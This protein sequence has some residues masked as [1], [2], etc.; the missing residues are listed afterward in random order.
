MKLKRSIRLQSRDVKV[1]N[2]PM[3]DIIFLLLTFFMISSSFSI[4]PGIKI[5]L[6]KTVT[7]ESQLKEEM[8]LTLNV[9]G[10]MFLNNE[11]VSLES[12]GPMLKANLPRSRERMLV[13]KADKEVRHGLVVNVMDIAKANGAEKLAIA[14]EKKMEKRRESK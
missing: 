3:A 11:P 2:T 1:D 9:K 4:Q 13:I 10:E 12:L 8:V 6:P 7:T 14:T 5:N